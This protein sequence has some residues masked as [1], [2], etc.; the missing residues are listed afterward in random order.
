MKPSEALQIHRAGLRELVTRYGV[1]HAG[2]FGSTIIGQDTDASDLDLLVEPS[3]STTLL[4]LSGSQNDA[5]ELLGVQ[6]SIL[7]PMCLPAR[8]RED[9]LRR[10]V[11]L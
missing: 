9:V 5:E 10:A 8:F 7:T 3:P 6:L 4:T 2:V 1:S 11:P